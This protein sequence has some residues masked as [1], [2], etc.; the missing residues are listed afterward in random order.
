[1]HQAHVVLI[2]ETW[3]DRATE[4]VDVPGYV[5][6]SRRDRK[7]GA[8]RGGILTLQREDFNGLAFNANN[9]ID[10]CGWHF[11]RL[12]VETILVGN[13]YR[14]GA[15]VHDGFAK[16]YEEVAIYYQEVS[17]VLLGGDLNVH[18]KKWLRF[19]NDNT[20]IGT[21]LKTL[22][23]FYGLNQ[24]VREPTRQEYLLDLILTDIPSC[25]ITVLPYIADHKG[26]LVKLP[27]PEVL[28]S[29]VAR[30]VWLLTKADWSKLR[31]ELL[32]YDW[33]GLQKGT[34]EDALNHFIE[35][36]WLHLVK[37]IPRRKIKTRKTNPT[38]G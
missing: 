24:L 32:A 1:M 37:H 14:P 8:N 30:E 5:Q 23:D 26:V 18:H 36:L 34:A 6:V 4:S 20:A 19:S 16:L 29:S 31:K 9:D 33:N 21:D 10:E 38:R 22:C 15:S 35:V 11:L 17:G 2:R 27:L 7:D 25:S 28:E 12:G 3:L 13:W